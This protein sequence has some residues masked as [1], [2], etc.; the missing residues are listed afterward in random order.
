MT[1]AP[2]VRFSVF[3]QGFNRGFLALQLRYISNG[4]DNIDLR[5]AMNSPDVVERDNKIIHFI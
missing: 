3:Y 1:S 4:G 2:E 5:E